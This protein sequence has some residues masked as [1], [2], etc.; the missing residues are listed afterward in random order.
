[1]SKAVL[2]INNMP[3]K[4]VDCPL[5][6]MSGNFDKFLCPPMQKSHDKFAKKKPDWCP[7]K[8]LSSIFLEENNNENQIT[9]IHQ[10]QTDGERV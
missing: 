6:E 10:T 3:D 4:C 2:V 8:P 1:M 9:E 5:H 7:L